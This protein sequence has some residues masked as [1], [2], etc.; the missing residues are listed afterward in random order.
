MD[1]AEGGPC[2]FLFL[3]F[4]YV[5]A[6]WSK[7]I[8]YALCS[9]N[10]NDDTVVSQITLQVQPVICTYSILCRFTTFQEA[11][12]F[13]FHFTAWRGEVVCVVKG[14]C[15]SGLTF[16]QCFLQ[17][18]DL[19]NTCQIHRFALRLLGDQL[20]LLSYSHPCA[21]NKQRNINSVNKPQ[22]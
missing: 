22:F 3:A 14:Q 17:F 2:Q 8:P 5:R 13:S 6:A 18:T 15:V 11:A 7:V 4:A 1:G 16:L 12:G 10:A 21:R 19:Y 20:Y 9:H